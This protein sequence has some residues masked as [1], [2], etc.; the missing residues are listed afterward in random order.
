[1]KVE[2][3]FV[4]LDN[5]HFELVGVIDDRKAKMS[6][7]VTSSLIQKKLYDT[8]LLSIIWLLQRSDTLIT[9]ANTLTV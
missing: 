1:M 9:S 6:F 8:I 5:S 2:I 3:A 7:L 4:A